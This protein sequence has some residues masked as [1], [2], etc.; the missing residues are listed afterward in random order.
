MEEQRRIPDRKN[1]INNKPNH[2]SNKRLRN[3]SRVVGP[4]EADYCGTDSRQ[5][6]PHQLFAS[7]R[8]R[9]SVAA[10]SEG[11]LNVARGILA[12]AISLRS[13]LSRIVSSGW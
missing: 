6:Q 13:N 9:H 4:Y 8:P 12:K 3:A 10:R 1:G 2:A 5:K 7:T 11:A